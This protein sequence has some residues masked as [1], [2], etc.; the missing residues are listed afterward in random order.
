MLIVPG[1][2]FRG[3]ERRVPATCKSIITKRSVRCVHVYR[4]VSIFRLE[5]DVMRIFVHI[6]RWKCSC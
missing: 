4:C 3:T 6:C 2:A 1:D 5:S